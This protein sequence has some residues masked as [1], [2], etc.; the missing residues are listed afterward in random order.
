MVQ[1]VLGELATVKGDF[2]LQRPEVPLVDSAGNT[3]KRVRSDVPDLILVSGKWDESNKTQKNATLHF[4]FRRG[5]P[6]PGEP[7]L[8]WTI[9]GENG[10]IRIISPQN[11]FIQVGDP[12]APRFI[13][14]HNFETGTVEKVEWEWE[15]WQQE[16][17]YPARS[18][19]KLYEDFAGVKNAEGK[20]GY[21]T[22]DLAA[23]RHE[24][25]QELLS[26]WEA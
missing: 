5:E 19:G 20:V 16:L 23:R 12:A 14:I 8:E 7:A 18:I 4:R 3:V 26:E 13:E 9:S 2:H 15:A 10:E 24:Q 25:L 11:T 1:G 21:V 6:F 17:P 22:F